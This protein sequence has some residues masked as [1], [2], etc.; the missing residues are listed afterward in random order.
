M[1]QFTERT[2]SSKIMRGA[3]LLMLMLIP[4][5]VSAFMFQRDSFI[6]RQL[7][8]SVTLNNK[9]LELT[10]KEPLKI[11]RDTQE[12]TLFPDPPIKMIYKKDLVPVD[13]RLADIEAELIDS[14]GGIHRSRPGL[15]ETMTGDLRVT[16][17]SLVFKDLPADLTYTSVRIRSNTKYRVKRIL[18]RCYNWAD[19]HH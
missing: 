6:D 1:W 15:S 9:W 16:S 19:V 12:L 18:W 13:G 11:E 2:I 8:S 7:S 4:T 17:R 10:P 14:K 5:A 3:V